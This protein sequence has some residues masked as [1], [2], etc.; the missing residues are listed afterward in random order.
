MIAKE[1]ET[2]ESDARRFDQHDSRVAV[3]I[4]AP[5]VNAAQICM[6]KTNSCTNPF[7][8]IPIC[9]AVS[10]RMIQLIVRCHSTSRLIVDL[11]LFRGAFLFMPSPQRVLRRRDLEADPRIQFILLPSRRFLYPLSVLQSVT[12]F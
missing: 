1:R 5:F 3:V 9:V 2:D 4:L 6:Y 11:F 12:S 10:N 8:A 7:D